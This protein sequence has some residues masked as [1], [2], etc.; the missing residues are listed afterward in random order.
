[1]IGPP[2]FAKQKRETAY[3]SHG[4]LVGRDE[5][6]G[7]GVEYDS[8]L[9]KD[10]EG[11]GDD[12]LARRELEKFS[13][14]AREYLYS[15]TL[16]F[17]PFDWAGELNA[18]SRFAHF[19]CQELGQTVVALPDSIEVVTM[20]FFFSVLLDGEGMDA[21]LA[22]VGSIETL[23]VADDVFAFLGR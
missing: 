8:E 15:A 11:N 2:A 6:V 21:D 7:N 4:E 9:V 12:G 18:G 17:N 20:D 23:D 13:A 16:P 10:T 3:R 22:V 19:S 1:M 14:I 5:G